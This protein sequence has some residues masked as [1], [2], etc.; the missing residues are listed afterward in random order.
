MEPEGKIDET[1]IQTNCQANDLGNQLEKLT[2][3][4][5]QPEIPITLSEP[6]QGEVVHKDE[7]VEPDVVQQTQIEETV[8]QAEEYQAPIQQV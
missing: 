1:C 4:E 7:V 5:V 3:D 6:E 8:S 2:V